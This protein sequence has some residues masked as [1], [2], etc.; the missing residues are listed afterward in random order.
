M[1]VGGKARL[2]CPADLAYGEAG[3]PN[4]PGG[5]TIIFEIEL[6]GIIALR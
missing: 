3:T 2:V 6:L 5:A 1:R 4:I